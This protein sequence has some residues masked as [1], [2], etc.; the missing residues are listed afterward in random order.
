MTREEIEQAL[1]RG[2]SVH[3]GSA[4]VDTITLATPRARRLASTLFNHLR[5][6]TVDA[7]RED[8]VFFE[9]L[10][11]TNTATEDPAA[12]Q[13]TFPIAAGV[14]SRFAPRSLEGSIR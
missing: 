14:C 5:S 1:L 6:N 2:E 13:V 8:Q 4:A 9:A 11:A 7:L 10:E 12:T 3:L